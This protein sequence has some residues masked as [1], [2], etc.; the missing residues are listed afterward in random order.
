MDRANKLKSLYNKLLNNTPHNL[1]VSY[2]VK[3]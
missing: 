1:T 2:K 3:T